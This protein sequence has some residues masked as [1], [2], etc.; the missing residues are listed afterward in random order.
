VN[1]NPKIG[2]WVSV[3]AIVL[4]VVAIMPPTTFPSYVPTT[5]AVAI[6]STCA[7]L[8]IIFN[9]I[10]GVLH[11]YSSSQPGPLAPPDPP[12]VKAATE[13]A[14][15]IAAVLLVALMVVVELSLSAPGA[16]AAPRMARYA[17]RPVA[18]APVKA[19]NPLQPLVDFIL[20]DLPAAVSLPDQVS[21][22]DPN[23]KLCW[24]IME[25]VNPVVK[26]H[27]LIFTSHAATDVEAQRL[28]MMVGH[29][30]CE[31]PSCNMVFNEHVAFLA[32][33]GLG[34]SPA[35]TLS[36]VCSYLTPISTTAAT[37]PTPAPTPTP[38]PIPT[39]APTPAPT[40]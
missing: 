13:A 12:A 18:T 23:G 34:I 24:Q 8:T 9:A 27:P 11:L 21:M 16:K 36:S 19:S 7:F 33:L 35:I 25:S 10:N 1:F 2:V 22:S 4:S 39:V 40:H 17:L 29:Q 20:S 26:A 14:S 32:R 3:V 5:L 28:L 31:D 37:A 15:K 30:V 6:I 38:T